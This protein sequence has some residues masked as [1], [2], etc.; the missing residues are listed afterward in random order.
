[1]GVEEKCHGGDHK[2]HKKSKAIQKSAAHDCGYVTTLVHMGGETV[3][4]VSENRLFCGNS[5]IKF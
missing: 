5:D 3:E 1:M 2:L 4:L